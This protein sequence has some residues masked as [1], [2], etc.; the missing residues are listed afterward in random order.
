[1]EK[2]FLLDGHSL[3]HRSFYALPLLTNESGEYTNSVFGFVRMLF[4]IIDDE[5][6]D[7]IA[8]A[9]DLKGPTFRHEEYE[10]YKAGR[11]KMPDE[12]KPQFD[13]VRDFLKVLNVPIFEKE[14]VIQAR[15]DV[16]FKLK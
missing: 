14:M 2:L 3:A 15:V 9:F 6:P 8:V 10:D 13:I 1:M 4:K 5:K 11:K 16:N 7:H 12:L